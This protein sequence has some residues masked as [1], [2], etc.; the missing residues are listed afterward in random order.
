[1]CRLL[2]LNLDTF[3]LNAAECDRGLEPWL[4]EPSPQ[5]SFATANIVGD[6]LVGCGSD[7]EDGL[8]QDY[9]RLEY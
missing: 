6:K 2:V 3:K 1:M 9:C 4:T 5:T 8:S 7:A